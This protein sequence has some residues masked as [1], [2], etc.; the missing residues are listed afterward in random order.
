MRPEQALQRAV[1]QYLQVAAPSDLFWTA[2]N[3]IPGKTPAAAA[4][5]KAMGLR[6]GVADLLFIHEGQALFIELKAK[7]GRESPSQRE[8]SALAGRAA[9]MTWICKSVEEVE[10][11]LRHWGVPL[12]ARAA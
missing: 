1:V 5:S 4:I 2:I 6:A 7:D 9:V 3:P 10:A 12:R 11:K 8:T